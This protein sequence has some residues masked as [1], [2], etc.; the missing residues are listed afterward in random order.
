MRWM[1]ATSTSVNGALLYASSAGPPWNGASSAYAPSPSVGWWRASTQ[2][3]TSRAPA[4]SAFC[5]SSFGIDVPS[6]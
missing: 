5:T 3:R 4:S 1:D 6:G 2:K